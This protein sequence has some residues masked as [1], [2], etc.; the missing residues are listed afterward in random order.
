MCANKI[1]WKILPDWDVLEDYFLKWTIF[2][3]SN[4][5]LQQK[6]VIMFIW[7]VSHHFLSQ[8]KNLLK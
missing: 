7:G 2:I 1:Q 5:D 8:D 4:V 6:I 3:G